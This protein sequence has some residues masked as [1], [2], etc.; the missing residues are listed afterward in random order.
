MPGKCLFNVTWLSSEKYKNWLAAD[1]D[2]SRARCKLCKKSFDI[3]NMGEAA[4]ASHAKGVKH[5]KCESVAREDSL[6][7]FF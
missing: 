1:S 2:A 6:D 5:G 3:S 4:L 7:S